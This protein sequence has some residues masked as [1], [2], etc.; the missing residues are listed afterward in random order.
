MKKITVVFSAILCVAAFHVNAQLVKQSPKQKMLDWQ[1]SAFDKD[2][3]YGAEINKAYDFLKGKQ[4]KKKPIIAM[5]GY[6]L[7]VQHE[8][9]KHQ[10]WTNPADKTDGIDND[11]NGLVDDVNG[12]NFL[13][14]A[15]G[16]VLNKTNKVADREFMRLK[17]KYLGIW[18]TGKEYVRF[19][20]VKDQPVVV[21]KP[22]NVAEFQYFRKQILTA[23][24]IGA[25]YMQAD[26]Y[27]LMKYYLFHDFNTAME[28]KHPDLTKVD[29][30]DFA[31]IA[32]NYPA[33]VDSVKYY[34]AQFLTL[35]MTFRMPVAGVKAP[36]MSFAKYKEFF[37]T[38]YPQYREKY[39]TELRKVTDNRS[40]VGDD[41]NN[42]NQKNYGNPDVFS[43]SAFYGTTAAGVIVA[44][45]NNDLGINGIVDAQLMPLKVYPKDGE[46][47][48]KDI[49]LAIRYAADH[50][51]DVI[52]L[53]M[54]NAICPEVEAK[55][56]SDALVYAE[57]KG[58]LVIAPVWDM[59][60]DL[61][62]KMYYPNRHVSFAKDLGNFISVAA[63]DEKGNPVKATNYSKTE[64]DLYA[65]G[66]N[67]STTYLG[68][69]YR[70]S[71]GSLV[72]ASV[73][74]GVAGLI[75]S[76]YPNLTGTQLRTLMLNNVT[77]RAGV[78]VEKTIKK[79]RGSVT[80]LYLLKDLSISGGIVNAYQAVKAAAVL[81]K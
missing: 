4:P 15:N 55:W 32:R 27:T 23:S 25:A 67:I 20:E 80:D 73:A 72:A 40:V 49:A 59:S 41:Q 44:Q 75:K 68:S 66:V 39:E 63:S 8:D 76:Y 26:V 54:P 37:M 30:A 21:P 5:V 43:N 69:T 34:A 19:D 48:Y 50:K 61:A 22:A 2:G 52:V 77:T 78:E 1:F 12:W 24:S 65:P 14:N 6:G 53:G 11:K 45:R 18:F 71:T 28:A 51:A 13:G 46:P 70:I 36:L 10:L 16:D 60:E 3:V 7:D 35:G 79:G 29:G 62:E 17:G 38:K 47:F 64:L 9:L 56:M 31:K 57:K 58:V 81:S 33:N 74:A 42:I